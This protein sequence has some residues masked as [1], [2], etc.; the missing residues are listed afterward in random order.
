M[1]DSAASSIMGQIRLTDMLGQKTAWGHD[2]PVTAGSIRAYVADKLSK[3]TKFSGQLEAL[4][5]RGAPDALLQEVLSGGIEGGSALASALLSAGDGDWSAITGDWRALESVSSRIGDTAT[6]SRFGTTASE[7]QAALD[8]YQAGADQIT[9]AI[10]RLALGLQSAIGAPLRR[11]GGGAVHGPGTS[12]SDSILTRLSD[13]E[14]VV[15]AAS[16]AANA[17]LVQAINASSG[18]VAAPMV[19]MPA[20]TSTAD[21]VAALAGIAV[22]VQVGLDRPTQGRIVLN[23]S[24]EAGRTDAAAIRHNLGV[25]S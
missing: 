8:A 17:G 4:R 24:R 22:M 2:T 1:H 5:Q 18:P 9:S 23:G 20:S 15:N 14:Y 21:I 7:A 3:A 6:R 10:D 19:A 16:Y 25:R 13:G 12:T 11:A